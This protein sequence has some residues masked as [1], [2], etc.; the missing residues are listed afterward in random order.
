MSAVDLKSWKAVNEEGYERAVGVNYIKVLSKYSPAVTKK[1]N[2]NF[3][4]PV[5]WPESWL[6]H[7]WRLNMLLTEYFLRID[8]TGFIVN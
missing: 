2:I 5:R 4:I 1:Y 3:R 7:Q 8:F 6:R